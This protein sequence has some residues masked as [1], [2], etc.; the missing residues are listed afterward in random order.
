[1]KRIQLSEK[2]INALDPICVALGFFDGLHKGHMALVDEVIDYSEQ[3]DMVKAVMTFDHY[4]QYVLGYVK[5]E[6][7]ITTI[8]DRE[9]LL[10][11]KGIDY[12]FVI[13][14]TK[15]VATLTPQE[16]IEEYLI[17]QNIKAIVCGFDFR[18][19][20]KNAGQLSDLEA[21]PNTH[22]SVIEPVIYKGEKISSSRIRENLDMGNVEEISELLGRPYVINGNVIKGRQIGRTIGFPTANLEYLK[23]YLPKNGVYAV[24]VLIGEQDYM[25][26]CNVGVNPTVGELNKRSLEVNIFDFE[27][28]LYNQNINIAFYKRM[29][30]EM[31]FN[32]VDQLKN[33]LSQ[34]QKAII[35]YF[36]NKS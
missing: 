35:S 1:M 3:H 29:R 20:S 28:D 30:E 17:K 36:N 10:K 24:K 34:D 14:F 12:L 21:I 11:E 32:G 16:F 19:G 26:M 23:Y 18:F 13:E 33:Q 27:G 15:E 31:M 5:E 2:E 8:A 22:L 7:V 25:G 9:K 4:P 6:N